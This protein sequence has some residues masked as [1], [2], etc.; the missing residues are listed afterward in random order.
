MVSKKFAKKKENG[1][2][3]TPIDFGADA[4]NV[5]LKSGKSVEDAIIGLQGFSMLS[6]F[7]DLSFNS[8]ISLDSNLSEYDYLY[9]YST[10]NGKNNAVQVIKVQDLTGGVQISFDNIGTD[11][12][13]KAGFILT[14]NTD[15]IIKVSNFNKVKITSSSV[16]F[17][18]EVSCQITGIYGIKKL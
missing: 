14:K 3:D 11:N 16:V 9:I 4:K 12:L 10:F 1:E 5:T 15:N 13:L 8:N 6:S 18:S 7:V 17:S 2:F